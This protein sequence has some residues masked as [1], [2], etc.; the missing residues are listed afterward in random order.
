M[1]ALQYGIDC[2]L[3]IYSLDFEGSFLVTVRGVSAMA[4]CKS[5][6]V[7]RFCF[8]GV[9]VFISSVA[10]FLETI[11]YPIIAQTN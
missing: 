9:F 10:I 7:V 5:V 1:L 8:I 4:I 6:S 2:F 3:A 11:I